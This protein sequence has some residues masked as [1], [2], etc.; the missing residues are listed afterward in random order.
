MNQQKQGL[1][2]VQRQLEEAQ[3]KSGQFDQVEQLLGEREPWLEQMSKFVRHWQMLSNLMDASA[4]LA[5]LQAALEKARDYM[6]ALR[7][8]F[9]A[10]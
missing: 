9:E 3:E 2:T 6:V 1:R 10:A 5:E 4:Q 8:R 7:R